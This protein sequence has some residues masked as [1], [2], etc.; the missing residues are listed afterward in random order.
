MA[1]PIRRSSDRFGSEHACNGD[2]R[3]V[4]AEGFDA[5]ALRCLHC[6]QALQL[7]R[8]HLQPADEFRDPLIRELHLAPIFDSGRRES[9]LR[10]KAQIPTLQ[11]PDVVDPVLHH[12]ETS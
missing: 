7:L 8:L 4:R 3:K 12:G 6:D 11:L 10:K 9:E 1:R 5:L 2:M